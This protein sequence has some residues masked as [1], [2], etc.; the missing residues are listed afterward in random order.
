MTKKK[1]LKCRQWRSTRTG[2]KIA[3]APTRERGG[4]EKEK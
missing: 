1:I 4:K 3:E 2:A